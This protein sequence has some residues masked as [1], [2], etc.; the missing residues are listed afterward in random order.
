MTGG[1]FEFIRHWVARTAS[2]SPRTRLNKQRQ[3]YLHFWYSNMYD[4]KALYLFL[5]VFSNSKQPLHA[6]ER[7]LVEQ[8]TISSLNE[9]N[10]VRGVSP[11]EKIVGPYGH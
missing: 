4:D 7:S 10:D 5:R 9:A 2:S 11:W 8:G 6:L 3:D 1:T